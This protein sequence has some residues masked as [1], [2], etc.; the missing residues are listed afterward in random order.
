LNFAPLFNTQSLFLFSNFTLALY[1]IK[2][3]FDF[4]NQIINRLNLNLVIRYKLD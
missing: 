3:H 1:D 2:L 4:K